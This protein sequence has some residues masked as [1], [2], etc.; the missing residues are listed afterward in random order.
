MLK[1]LYVFFLCTLLTTSLSAQKVRRAAKALS[2]S[3]FEKAL[4]LFGEVLQKDSN[5]VPALVGYAKSQLVQNEFQKNTISLDVLQNCFSFLTRSKSVYE[6]LSD[7]DNNFLKN[8]LS[9]NN[10]YSI[11]SLL[12]GYTNLMWKDYITDERSIAKYELFK[13]NYF[14]PNLTTTTNMV[15]DKLDKLYFDSVSKVNEIDAYN[16]Y[17]NKFKNGIFI[18]DAKVKIILLEYN[19]A[20]ASSGIEKLNSFTLKYPNTKYTTQAKKEIEKREFD[21]AVADTGVYLLEKFVLKYPQADQVKK[22][23]QIAEDRDY[24][25]A[26]SNNKAISYECFLSKYPNTVHKEGLEDT[27]AQMY[28]E[29]TLQSNNKTALINYLGKLQKFHS[30]TL[31]T[32]YIDS[33]NNKIYNLEY[34][35]ANTTNDLNVLIQFVSNYKNTNRPNV[36]LIR[37]KLFTVW[38]QYIIKDAA[39]P[40]K[41][42]LINFIEEFKEMDYPAFAKTIEAS[43]SGLLKYL[44]SLKPLIVKQILLNNNF[45]ANYVERLDNLS[46]LIANKLIFKNETPSVEIYNKLKEYSSTS[47]SKADFIKL[48]FSNFRLNEFNLESLLESNSLLVYLNY[49]TTNTFVSK[50]YLWDFKTNSYKETSEINTNNSICKAIMKRYGV[51]SFSNPMFTEIVNWKGQYDVRFY[52][53]KKADMDCC[54]TFV[55]NLNYEI[56]NNQFV[57]IGASSINYSGID[58]EHQEMSRKARH[59]IFMNDEIDIN[60]IISNVESNY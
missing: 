11:D 40:E 34:I 50:L 31:I 19:A 33:C 60:S 21:K 6:N 51:V 18:N 49:Q 7:E 12:M 9:I 39:K 57:P 58:I 41:N 3:K 26:K 4:E 29:P 13:F 27:I 47:L 10:I 37:K 28:F 8:E 48:F 17:R 52:G 5:S 56:Q 15:E 38:E 55:I 44:D 14:V 42:G 36:D 16:F 35:E 20:I 32:E 1:Y 24:L 53:Y 59:V 43:K 23:K 25:V 45:Y 2:E 54:P 30:S 46:N 22:A